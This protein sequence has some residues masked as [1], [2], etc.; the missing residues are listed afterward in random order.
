MP[1]RVQAVI[2]ANGRHTKYSIASK[3]SLK[4][5]IKTMANEAIALVRCAG[6]VQT[7]YTPPVAR[8]L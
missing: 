4:S 2:A 5:S 6:G 8:T 1:H 7:Y 3:I